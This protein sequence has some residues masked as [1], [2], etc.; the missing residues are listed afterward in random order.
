MVHLIKVAHLYILNAKNNYKNR[1]MEFEKQVKF[2][3]LNLFFRLKYLKKKKN[4]KWFGNS[5]GG[6]YVDTTNL[7]KN[8]VVY[9]FGI[10]EDVS[11]D[12]DIIKKTQ[13][14]VYG[15]GPTP[16][17]ISWIQK[18]K[19]NNFDFS[20]YGIGIENK[21]FK[22]FLPKNKNHVSGSIIKS[23][24]LG[25]DFVEIKLKTL[26]SIMKKK[27]HSK[28]DLLKLDIEGSEYEVL[29][30][31]LEKN[32]KISQIVVEFHDRFIKN[33]SRLRKRII[34]KLK[35]DGYILFAVSRTLEEYSFI[36]K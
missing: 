18:R 19:I 22:M 20:D 27:N 31:I 34:K 25:D 32:I 5:Y 21:T 1:K 10:G 24:H 26:D 9:S 29:E 28:L 35:K 3:L 14:Y 2:L 30:Y 11:F 7:N 12:E 23:K 6:F 17:S 13:A 4:I 36:K 8:S 33:G 15:F 16:R